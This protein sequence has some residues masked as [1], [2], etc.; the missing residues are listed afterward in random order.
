MRPTKELDPKDSP[1][2]IGKLSYEST[3]AIEE[4]MVRE[5]ERTVSVSR[6]LIFYP[7]SNDG[8]RTLSHKLWGSNTNPFG[9]ITNAATLLTI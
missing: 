2:R 3:R 5:L 1:F 9:C 4:H 6:S 8:R 7:S